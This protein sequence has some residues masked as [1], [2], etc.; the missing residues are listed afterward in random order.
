MKRTIFA[1]TVGFVATFVINTIIA[2]MIIG[3]FFNQSLGI[4]RTPEQGLQIPA[5]LIGYLIVAYGMTWIL[6]HIR[7]DGWLRPGIF[8]G[9]LTGVMVFAAGHMIIAGWSTVDTSALIYSGLFDAVSPMFGAVAIA[10]V[11]HRK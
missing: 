7:R 3:P 4:V 2:L 9:G 1:V 10:Y 6:Q 8:V 11:L 5:I